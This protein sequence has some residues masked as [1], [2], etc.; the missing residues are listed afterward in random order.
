MLYLYR[1]VAVLLVLFMLNDLRVFF[2]SAG[3]FKHAEASKQSIT[4]QTEPVKS[5]T[6]S[7]TPSESPGANP[8]SQTLKK[9]HYGSAWPGP[10]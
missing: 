5:P 3:R 7:K 10:L 6:K 9:Q 4:A 2:L 1:A 8:Q